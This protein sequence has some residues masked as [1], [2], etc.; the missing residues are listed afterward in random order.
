MKAKSLL[1]GLIICGAFLAAMIPAR[2]ETYPSRVIRIIV[3]FPAG[4]QADFSS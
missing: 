3:P 4:G 1:G 2:A